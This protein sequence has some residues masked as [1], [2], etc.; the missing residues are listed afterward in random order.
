MKNL[1]LTV[2]FIL[3]VNSLKAQEVSY[4]EDNTRIIITSNKTILSVVFKNANQ[5]PLKDYEG[6]KRY[7]IG[8]NKFVMP[9]KYL[10]NNET[11]VVVDCGVKQVVLEL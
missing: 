9:V 4:N 11:F 7:N 8:R 10:K 5:E 6:I 2:L 1:I 3:S